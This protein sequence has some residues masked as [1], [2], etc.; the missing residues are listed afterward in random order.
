MNTS[1]EPA[2][3]PGK[4]KGTTILHVA[5]NGFAPRSAAASSQAAAHCAATSSGMDSSLAAASALAACC[6]AF[7]VEV[8]LDQ[9]LVQSER[10]TGG[11]EDAAAVDDARQ[12]F[13][14]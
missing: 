4:L 5:T 13:D 11:V 8:G 3:I 1:S 2:T 10:V 9:P 6:P 14:G 12:S 7:L